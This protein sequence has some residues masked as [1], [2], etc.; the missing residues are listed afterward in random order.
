MI[1]PPFEPEELKQTAVLPVPVFTW[2]LLGIFLDTL[3]F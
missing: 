2:Y 3:F 1:I